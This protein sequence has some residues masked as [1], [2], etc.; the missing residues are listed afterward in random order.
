MSA[1]E[2]ERM[3]LASTTYDKAYKEGAEYA[4]LNGHA[5]VYLKTDQGEHV[6][7]KIE[8]EGPFLRTTEAK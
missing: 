7:F 1:G 8:K 6:L 3:K 2:I 4:L 5:F